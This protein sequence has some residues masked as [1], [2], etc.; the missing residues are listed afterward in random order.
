MISVND[1]VPTEDC[2]RNLYA[3]DSGLLIQCKDFKVTEE[4]LT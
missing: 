2:D 4:Q 1:M 3:D